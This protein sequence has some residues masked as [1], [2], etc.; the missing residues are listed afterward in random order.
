MLYVL[1]RAEVAMFAAVLGVGTGK[2]LSKPRDTSEARLVGVYAARVAAAEVD[3]RACRALDED[4]DFGEL[5]VDH[6][7]VRDVHA[8]L[9]LAL[10]GARD[11]IPQ[12]FST[13]ANATV[14]Y[15]AAW[16]PFNDPRTQ[17]DCD[18]DERRRRLELQ[19]SEQSVSDTL[20]FVHP[21]SLIWLSVPVVAPDC[22]VMV[23]KNSFAGWRSNRPWYR[24]AT[25]SV[26]VTVSDVWLPRSLTAS[27]V[28]VSWRLRGLSTLSAVHRRPF[29][30]L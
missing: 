18:D 7:S 11:L 21:G 13:K 26:L 2:A 4:A 1:I 23:T 19:W 6:A 27:P 29:S 12:Q 15:G 3:A 10:G 8:A 14:M 5:L 30:G 24:A 16:G 20:V 9:L 22:S 17:E 25:Q 28:V